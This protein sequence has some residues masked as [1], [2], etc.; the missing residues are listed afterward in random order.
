M[1]EPDVVIRPATTADRPAILEL[2]ADALGWAA[3]EPH[4]ELFAWKH[5]DN[6]FGASPMWVAESEGRL[7]GFR[8]FLR[9]RFVT[10]SGSSVDAVRAVDTA[11]APSF[12]GRGIFTRLTLAA[13]EDLR[14]EGVAFVF[15]TPNDQSRPGYLK[16]GWEQLGRV[17]V[18]VRVRSPSA[19]A[20]MARARTPADKWSLPLTVGEPA[21]DGFTGEGARALLGRLPPPRGLTTARSPVFLAWRYGLAHLA[22]RVLADPAGLEHG[23]VVFRARRRGAATE[24]VVADELA[25]TAAAGRRLV[26]R[27]AELTG[28]DYLIRTGRTDLA[29]RFVTLPRQGPILTWRAVT[30]RAPTPLGEWQL[31]LGDIELF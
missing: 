5:D 14:T 28:A 29:S 18:A 21:A 26:R 7:A 22:Y 12:Q 19:A 16:M 3:G 24:V 30:A 9:W 20:R 27:V 11:T 8:T 6:P 23:A 31:A 25:P 10:A 2:A 17:P 1:P 15:N 4:G 13:L